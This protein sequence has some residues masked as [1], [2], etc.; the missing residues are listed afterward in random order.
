MTEL[1]DHLTRLGRKSGGLAKVRELCEV[2][3]RVDKRKYGDFLRAVAERSGNTVPG[4][5]S[6]LVAYAIAGAICVEMALVHEEEKHAPAYR[7]SPHAHWNAA[8]DAATEVVRTQLANPSGFDGGDI[9]A[10]V[11][12]LRKHGGHK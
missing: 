3:S 2:L 1:S 5:A 7:L 4:G 9:L 10:A 11:E 8:I 12:A 6:T